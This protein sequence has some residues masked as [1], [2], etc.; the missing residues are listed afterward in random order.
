MP[1]F[2]RGRTTFIVVPA[3]SIAWFLCNQSSDL[4]YS[5]VVGSMVEPGLLR[6]VAVWL[7]NELYYEFEPTRH[8]AAI[9]PRPLIM[10]NGRDDPQ[11]PIKAVRALYAAAGEPKTLIW[12]T[13]GHLLPTDT[14]LIRVLVD[15]TLAR[16]PVL[17][18]GKAVRR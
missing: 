9:A 1:S 3:L 6:R 13:T 15:T 7:A 2:S 11:M 10:I 5:A 17:E 8:V 14:A 18:G 4:T 16:L 12:L